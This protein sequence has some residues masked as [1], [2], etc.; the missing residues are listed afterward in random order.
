MHTADTDHRTGTEVPRIGPVGRLVRVF[1]AVIMALFGF[2]WLEAGMTWFGNPSTPSHAWVWVV[3]G[4]AA[5]YGLHQ[6]PESGLGRPW[7]ERTLAAAGV[8]VA[9]AALATLTLNGEL[10]AP[11]LTTLLYGL[12]VTFLF[13]VAISYVVAVFL[14]TPGCEVGGLGELIRRLRGVPHAAD[15][16]AMWCIVGIHCLDAWEAERRRHTTP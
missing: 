14:G 10:W 16:E 8:V 6:L 15:H 2:D 1:G 5:Y 4:L 11:P 3:T 7:G 12:D 9:A 13:V